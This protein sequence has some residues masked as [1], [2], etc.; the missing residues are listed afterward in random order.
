ML[1]LEAGRREALAVIQRIQQGIQRNRKLNLEN[2]GKNFKR[3]LKISLNQNIKFEAI[4]IL[5]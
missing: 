3:Q 1:I 5:H 4:I 2:G